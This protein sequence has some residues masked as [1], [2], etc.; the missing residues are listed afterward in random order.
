[1]T[2]HLRPNQFYVSFFLVGIGLMSCAMVFSQITQPSRF[3][4]ERKYSDH[5]YNLIS[6]H[7]EGIALIHDNEK[8]EDGKKIWEVILL[9]STLNKTWSGTLKLNSRL[10]FIGYEYIMGNLYLL[11]RNGELNSNDLHLIHHSLATHEMNT[12]EIK[13]QVDFRITHFSMAGSNAIFG[14]YIVR[15]PAVFLYSITE[16]KLKVV[17]GFFLNDTELLDLRINHNNTF[18]VLMTERGLKDQKKLIVRTY[19]ESGTM[20]MDDIITVDRD[21]NLIAG[22]TSSLLKDEMIVIGTY[23]VGKS[24]QASG[25]FSVMVDP[26]SE[27][28]IRYTDLTQFN[29]LLDYLGD[30]RATKLKQSGQ[31][32]RQ[33]GKSPAFKSN[34][35]LVRVQEIPKGFLL[36]A[37]VYNSSTSSS[38]SSY[39]NTNPYGNGYTPYGPNSNYN[40]RFY[41][42]PYS[43]SPTQN[44]EVKMLESTVILF[45]ENG[46]PG[47]DESFKFDNI[48]YTALE[49]TSDFIESNKGIVLAYKKESKIFSKNTIIHDATSKMDTTDI[50]LKN[51]ADVIRNESE[52][53]GG[54]RHWYNNYFYTWGYQSITNPSKKTEDPNRHVFYINKMGVE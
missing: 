13:H 12:Y 49:Q 8:Y 39:W 30:K 33:N 22:I 40:N 35:A 16:T 27:Q 5:N 48:K 52:D 43:T 18:N 41:N 44:T 28:A 6:L 15:E 38:N 45:D 47:W 2:A 10:Q 51:E 42:T 3:E 26:F 34:I 36:L 19:D 46:L 4:E 20:L 32:Q 29:H 7:K 23:G 1:M 25:F 17:P 21:I 24:R 54:V 14:G 37:E 50:K 11:F 53:D 31:Q 9:D